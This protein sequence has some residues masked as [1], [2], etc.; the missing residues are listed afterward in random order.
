MA[1]ALVAVLA[2]AMPAQAA[3]GGKAASVEADRTRLRATASRAP[4]VGFTDTGL[5]ADG[6]MTIHEFTA[7][8]GTVF[9]V[10]WR[11]PRRPDL[12]QLF[13]AAYFARF[14]ADN[15]PRTGHVYM[16]RALASTH[17]DFVVRTG[18]YS[19]AQWGYAYLPARIPA[20]FDARNL[21]Q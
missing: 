9:A 13:G 1:A 7:D 19:G 5:S 8:D 2:Q 4:G 18:G 11:G 15:P 20:G 3:L 10:A 16:R 6:G 12:K 14:Q 21:Q 17:S